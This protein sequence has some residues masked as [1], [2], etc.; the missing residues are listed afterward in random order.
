MPRKAVCGT[1]GLYKKHTAGCANVKGRP[2]DC[3]CPWWAGYL[4]ARKHRVLATAVRLG[5]R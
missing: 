2:T 5:R 1:R 3:D 4:H